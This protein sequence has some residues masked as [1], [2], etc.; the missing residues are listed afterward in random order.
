MNRKK[1]VVPSRQNLIHMKMKLFLLAAG[2][3]FLVFSCKRGPDQKLV[4]DMKTDIAKYESGPLALQAFGKEMFEM[5]TVMLTLPDDIKTK[6]PKYNAEEAMGWQRLGTKVYNGSYAYDKTLVNL[7]LLTADYVDGLVPTDSARVRYEYLRAGLT[8]MPT[9]ERF[10]PE[11]NSARTSYQ[12]MT[13]TV[14]DSV[15]VFLKAKAEAS[16]GDK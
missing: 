16:I 15:L 4:N 10:Q 1:P 5:G 7:K 9:T 12:Q 11:L 8:G 6:V 14:P 3:L 2:C 13:A